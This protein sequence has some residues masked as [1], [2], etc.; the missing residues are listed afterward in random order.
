MEDNQLVDFIEV[1]AMGMHKLYKTL[2]KKED[3]QRIYEFMMGR[4]EITFPLI[5][6]RNTTSNVVSDGIVYELA[7]G[8]NPFLL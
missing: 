6:A 2:N 1:Y 4:G 8:V 7:R 3:L 5:A